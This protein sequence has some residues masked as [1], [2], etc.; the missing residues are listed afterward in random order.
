MG[1]RAG[2]D[3]HLTP[4]NHPV[5]SRGAP[6][7]DADQAN[8]PDLWVGEKRCGVAEW[9]QEHVWQVSVTEVHGL[10]ARYDREVS[11]D[12]ADAIP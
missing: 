2:L 8:T 12:V 10:R 4:P 11:P 9:L 3:P 6:A 5:P 1:S 7:D